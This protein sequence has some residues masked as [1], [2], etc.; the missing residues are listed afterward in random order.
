MTMA[1]VAVRE[2]GILFSGPMK[3]EE[4]RAVLGLEGRYEVSNFG[5]VRSLSRYRPAYFGHIL[6]PQ[7][8]SRGYE[9]LRLRAADGSERGMSVHR[10][11]MQVFVGPCPKG[12]QVAHNDGDR[13]N[14]S[15]SNLRYATPS[16]NIDDRHRH[17]RT[18]RGSR[19]GSA[20]LD[21][22]AALTISKLCDSG[23]SA[24]E[25]AHLACVDPSTVS[26]IWNGENWRH[27]T[28]GAP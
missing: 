21:E 19:S 13:R 25:I 4:W 14:N 5:R 27:V 12:M 23:L 22:A 24:S 3:G 15:L 28:Q 16:S 17:G 7:I 9:S 10:L 1:S 26:A 11:V 8:T 20:K 18:A 2:R 6:T